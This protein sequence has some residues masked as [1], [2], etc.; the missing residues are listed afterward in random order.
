MPN[1]KYRLT[2]KDKAHYW[3]LFIFL[4]L[5]GLIIGGSAIYVAFSGVYAFS[6][7]VFI[8]LLFGVGGAIFCGWCMSWLVKEYKHWIS[9]EKEDKAKAEEEDKKDGE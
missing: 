7:P 1:D 5:F 8:Y 3:F 6:L 4:P 2:K 9:K